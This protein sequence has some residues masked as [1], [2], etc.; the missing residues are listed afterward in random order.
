MN[1]STAYNKEIKDWMKNSLLSKDFILLEEK[2]MEKE[3]F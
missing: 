3:G 2:L 1:N